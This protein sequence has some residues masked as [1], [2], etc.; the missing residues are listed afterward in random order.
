MMPCHRFPC[1]CYSNHAY[2][3]ESLRIASEFFGHKDVV[4]SQSANS[5]KVQRL[6]ESLDYV[7]NSWWLLLSSP[8]EYEMGLGL[9]VGAMKMATSCKGGMAG[10][11]RG[12]VSEGHIFKTWCQQ[13]L[14]TL[15]S[16]LWFIFKITIQ[17]W[18][19]LDDFTFAL[20]VGDVTKDPPRWWQLC[21]KDIIKVHLC[22]NCSLLLS[23]TL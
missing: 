14:F 2:K 22:R 9:V 12:S 21:K 8:V 16:L 7:P 20:H 15:E 3:L 18:D 5:F 13:G 19:A 1:V 17:V 10:N 11:Q 23:H 6:W 4:K